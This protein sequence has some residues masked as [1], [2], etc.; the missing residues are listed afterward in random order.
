MAVKFIAGGLVILLCAITGR[1]CAYQKIREADGIR[2]MQEDIKRL[3]NRTLERRLSASD[4]LSAL[5]GESFLK[6]RGYLKEDE[7]LTLRGAW[8]KTGGA[9]NGCEEENSIVALLFDE[10]E[11]LGRAEQ[12]K[13]FER[14][15]SDLR[16]REEKKRKEGREKIKLYTSLGALTGFCAVIFLV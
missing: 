13:E 1:A 14:A 5:E 15:L 10:L 12:E 2:H 8:E 11:N 4:A 16:I 9:G 7:A 6:M 3:K